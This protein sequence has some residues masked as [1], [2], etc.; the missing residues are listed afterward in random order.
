MSA[1]AS[2]YYC[3]VMAYLQRA[4]TSLKTDNSVVRLVEEQGYV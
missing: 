4:S 1:L 2:S 3:S